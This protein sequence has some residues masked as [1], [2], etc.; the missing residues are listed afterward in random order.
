MSQTFEQGWAARPFK[1]QFPFLPDREAE[2][3]DRL[4]MAI[5]DMVMADLITNSQLD[6]I[7]HKR[8]PKLV[9]EVV[10]AYQDRHA[11]AADERGQ[12]E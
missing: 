11:D 10:R 5:T 1:E 3:L 12:D 7:R 2:R 9:G 4:N 6:S 8:F